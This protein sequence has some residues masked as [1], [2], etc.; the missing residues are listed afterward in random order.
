M[1]KYKIKTK[2]CQLIVKIKISYREKLKKSEWDIYSRTYIRGLFRGQ[3]KKKRVLE[4]TGPF[5]ISLFERLKKPISK[6]DFFFIMEQIA[7]LI[8]RLEKKNLPLES[9]V[10]DLHRVFI[11]QTT[12]EIQFF[13]LPL[14]QNER[15]TN[16][17]EFIESIIY[18]LIPMQGQDT[19]YLS[20]F[21]YFIKGLEPFDA[22]KIEKY[23]LQE[24]Q[25]VV[26]IVKRH[27][28]GQ[29]G[30]MTDK[31]KDYYEHYE[32]SYPDTEFMQQNTYLLNEGNEGTELLNDAEA[33]I[34]EETGILQENNMETSFMNDSLKMHFPVLY[35][36]STDEQITVNKPVFRIGKD[37]HCSDCFIQNNNT[38]SRNHADVIIRDN[39]YFVMDLGSKNKTFLNEQE[40]PAQQETEIFNGD[41]LR[42]SNEE[43]TFYI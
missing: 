20:R 11:N 33:W 10:F 2:D 31:Q 3:M 41:C 21:V 37:E 15:T 24:E 27:N 16:V 14:E 8:Q 29:S 26:N 38:V 23:I 34:T 5:G 17:G 40:L 4:Y 39:R 28:I 32:D 30:Y 25:K 7:D 13:Y 36:V 18:T 43:F 12:K 1:A 42:F 35:R 19:E 6:Y 22:M 9:V